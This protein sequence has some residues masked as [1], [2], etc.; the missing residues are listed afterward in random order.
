M[1]GQASGRG[2]V[3]VGGRETGG[4]GVMGGGE[5]MK[6]RFGLS[7]PGKI[8][9]EN[10][11]AA[12]DFREEV[13]FPIAELMRVNCELDQNKVLYDC[14][15]EGIFARRGLQTY[16]PAQYRR[17]ELVV[18][19]LC[20][21][22][23]DRHWCRQEWNVIQDLS[24]DERSRARVMYLWRGERNDQVVQELGLDW[25]KDGFFFIDNLKPK[26][27]FEEIH[28]R[29]K[30]NCVENGDTKFSDSPTRVSIRSAGSAEDE[31]C[32]RLLV[33]VGLMKG[34]NPT[35]TRAE[36]WSGGAALES[37]TWL[38][39]PKGMDGP[40]G[41]VLTRKIPH[42]EDALQEL[43]RLIVHRHQLA[44]NQAEREA[45][46]SMAQVLVILALPAA[47]LADRCLY[48]LLGMIRQFCFASEE[49]EAK[50]PPAIVL[51]CT[52]RLA[53]RCTE[54]DTDLQD[55]IAPRSGWLTADTRSQKISKEIVRCCGKEAR[56]LRE[57]KWWMIHESDQRSSPPGY[58]LPNQFSGAEDRIHSGEILEDMERLFRV[59]KQRDRDH[60]P[61]SLYLRW[62]E[63]LPKNKPDHYCR[64]MMRILKSG[65]P[66][67]WMD[68]PSLDPG[69]DPSSNHQPQEESTGQA[70][71][72]DQLL[73]WNA[74]ELLLNFTD[75]HQQIDR[76]TGAKEA[77]IW[78]YVRQGLLFW[79]DH[80]YG[81]PSGSAKDRSPGLA[82][83]DPL[84]SPF[85]G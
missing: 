33:Q 40:V 62:Q 4:W 78:T 25:D 60:D 48:T 30:D 47:L 49:E 24:K 22:Y 71:P 85:F 50:E 53:A 72:L 20:K 2:K 80:R 10:T 39:S 19:F 54:V 76:P 38:M 43:A 35:K 63:D 16:L 73:R 55:D 61:Q 34:N 5:D 7:F 17:C 21:E 6:Y 8:T 66:L 15:H 9:G 36:T 45:G 27:I 64:R 1:D 83:T 23:A 77:A 29:Y 69:D 68:S 74:S 52:E 79:D 18:A 56:A 11:A 84:V 59:A 3:R 46:D 81:P 31:T 28:K 37:F 65:V 13:V 42:K 58:S 12:F 32:W 57:L 14:Y 26:K 67:F 41:N 44:C 51:A 70:H 75:Q 82:R